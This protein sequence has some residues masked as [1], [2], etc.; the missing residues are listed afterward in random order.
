MNYVTFLF[1]FG[2]DSQKRLKNLESVLHYYRKRW[3][4]ISFLI[5]E[6]GKTPTEINKPNNT[7]YI[8]N[9]HIGLHSQSK[10]INFGI[11]HIKSKVLVC[12]DAD[13][14]LTD[15]INL[16]IL[17]RDIYL[18]KIDYGLPYDECLDLPYFTERVCYEKECIG[19]IFAV[20]LDKF[21]DIG[22]Q[23]EKYKGWGSEDNERHHRLIHNN[24]RFKRIPGTIFHLEHPEQKKKYESAEINK[25]HLQ[26]DI[27]SI[28]KIQEDPLI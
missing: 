15:Y 27:S 5:S 17:I 22:G 16:D 21:K 11:K 20:N 13:I 25:Q 18:D 23:S 10:V 28:D 19:G 12:I 1:P 6:I 24:F 9:S 8:F 3:P 7:D 4:S 2:Y 14:I 26:N